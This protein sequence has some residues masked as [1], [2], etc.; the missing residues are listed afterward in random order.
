MTRFRCFTSSFA[1][2]THSTTKRSQLSGLLPSVKLLLSVRKR[3]SKFS[4]ISTKGSVKTDF[5]LVIREEVK[6]EPF[7]QVKL[8]DANRTPRNWNTRFADVQNWKSGQFISN[9][10]YTF[11][12]KAFLCNLRSLRCKKTLRIREVILKF[13]TLLFTFFTA[14]LLHTVKKLLLK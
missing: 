13:S 2:Y 5:P 12:R 6:P 9:A 3:D 8:Y 14:Q 1:I 4:I 10:Y 7:S 11:K